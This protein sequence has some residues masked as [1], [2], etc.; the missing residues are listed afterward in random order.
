MKKAKKISMLLI[1]ISLIMIFSTN[2]YASSKISKGKVKALYDTFLSKKE[3]KIGNSYRNTIILENAYFKTVDIDGN[4]I[5]E[6][7]IK[8]RASTYGVCNPVAYI[9][10]IKNRKVAYAGS[11]CIKQDYTNVVQISKRYKSIYSCYPVAFYTPTYFYTLKK[12]KLR[13]KKFFYE[14]YGYGRDTYGNIPHEKWCKSE[15]YFINKK[16]VSENKYQKE[17]QKYMRSLKK[18][19]LAVNTMENRKKQL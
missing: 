12:G 18:Y 4:G 6:L 2:V 15:G 14:Q 9:F 5:K 11:T 19:F 3:V 13:T 16:K 17:Y 8:E 10:T 1:S 7:I